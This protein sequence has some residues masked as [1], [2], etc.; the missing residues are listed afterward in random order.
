MSNVDRQLLRQKVSQKNFSNQNNHF[1][2][3]YKNSS[4]WHFNSY[5][6]LNTTKTKKFLFWLL[7]FFDIWCDKKTLILGSWNVHFLNC[8]TK[9]RSVA[10]KFSAYDSSWKN[11]MIYRKN[12]RPYVDYIFGFTQGLLQIWTDY[13]FDFIFWK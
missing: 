4:F 13:S 10:M 1:W 6:V 5:S 11:K 12:D 9:V 7:I 3:Y 2:W 8:H